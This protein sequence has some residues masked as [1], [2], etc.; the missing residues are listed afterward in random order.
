[1]EMIVKGRQQ[2]KKEYLTQQR[3]GNSQAGPQTSL[4]VLLQQ[5]SAV[6]KISP[7]R[8]ESEKGMRVR[9]ARLERREG[10]RPISETGSWS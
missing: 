9:E 2:E 10:Y 6:F 7:N 3:L 4:L 1:M 8:S 5:L